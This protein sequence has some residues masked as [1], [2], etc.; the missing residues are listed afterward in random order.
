MALKNK[1]YFIP[2]QMRRFVG[3]KGDGGKF[4]RRIE[5]I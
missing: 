4:G 3:W 2:N 1:K 5:V